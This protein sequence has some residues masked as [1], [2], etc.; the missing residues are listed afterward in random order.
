MTQEFHAQVKFPAK[1]PALSHQETCT[2][3]LIAALLKVTQ[4]WKQPEYL[5]TA[6][7]I[8]NLFTSMVGAKWVKGVTG[9]NF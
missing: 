4:T 7:K 2:E 1:I 3:M 5:T 8:K 6:E 9:T